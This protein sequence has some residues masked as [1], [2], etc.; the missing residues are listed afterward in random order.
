MGKERA[1]SSTKKKHRRRDRT[2]EPEVLECYYCGKV[3]R[4]SAIRCKFCRKWYSSG[5]KTIAVFVAIMALTIILF[6]ATLSIFGGEEQTPFS[7]NFDIE[8][9]DIEDDVV[10]PS[11]DADISGKVAEKYDDHSFSL[12]TRDRETMSMSTEYVTLDENVNI[13][14]I[15]METNIVSRASISDIQI[16]SMMQ[17]WGT[18]NSDGSWHGTDVGLM[19]GRPDRP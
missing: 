5:K 8:D 18:E 16:S 3:V 7:P 19:I 12:E 1:S 14:W 15:D 17:V 4:A 6:F 9:L 2:K 10:I 11:G 13:F